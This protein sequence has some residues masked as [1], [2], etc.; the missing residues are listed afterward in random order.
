MEA[1]GYSPIFRNTHTIAN[2]T[3]N[4]KKK[5]LI[6]VGFYLIFSTAGALVVVTV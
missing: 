1:S 2:E 5:L 3:K 4:T 6:A